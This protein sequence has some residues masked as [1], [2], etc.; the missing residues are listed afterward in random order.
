[1]NQRGELVALCTKG[2]DGMRLVVLSRLVALRATLAAE[3]TTRTVWTGITLGRQPEG[4]RITDVDINSPASD[5]GVRVGDTITAVDGGAVASQYQFAAVIRAH[6][7]GDVIQLA[8][9]AA[10]DS[11]RTIDLVLARPRTDG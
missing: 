6:H 1:L 4:L 3:A 7:P 5:A 8:L 9:R 2:N 11:S 10:D